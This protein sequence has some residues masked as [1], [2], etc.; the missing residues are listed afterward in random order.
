MKIIIGNPGSG[1]TKK[2]LELSAENNIPILCESLARQERLLEKAKGYG[3][4]IPQ[5][6]VFDA[7]TPDVK[8]VYIDDVNRLLDAMLH[9]D[10]AGMTINVEKHSIIE[11]L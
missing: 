6:I 11:E 9:V 1:K 4:S 8:T 10:V 3:L 2:V 5:P 7:V